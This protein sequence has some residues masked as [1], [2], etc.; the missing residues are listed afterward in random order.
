MKIKVFFEW[1]REETNVNKKL[2]LIYL[3]QFCL[4]VTVHFQLQTHLK[5]F[6]YTFI[7]F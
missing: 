4:Y 1:E 3:K 5:T 2:K 6:K 7:F